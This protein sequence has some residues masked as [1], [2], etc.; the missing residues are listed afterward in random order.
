MNFMALREEE[1]ENFVT[2]RQTKV[3]IGVEP[4]GAPSMLNACTSGLV[5]LEMV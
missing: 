5:I 2:L 4:E 1:P 3:F